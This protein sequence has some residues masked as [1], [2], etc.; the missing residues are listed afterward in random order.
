MA[1]TI[2]PADITAGIPGAHREMFLVTAGELQP[3]CMPVIEAFWEAVRHF[4]PAV[5]KG[6]IAHVVFGEAPFHLSMPSGT[7][8]FSPPPQVIN[9]AIEHLIFLDIRKMLPLPR[10]L[11]VACIVE[12]FVHAIMHVSDE[13]I[14]SHVVALL[15]PG[16][17]VVND[18]YVV[19]TT[20]S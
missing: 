10:G 1:S 4:A 3:V 2:S 9:A 20:R 6:R 14:T 17:S 18:Q 12:E 8:S 13:R 5:R 11:Q 15:Y 16:I 7:L 19:A